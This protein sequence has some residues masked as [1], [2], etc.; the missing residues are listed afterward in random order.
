MVEDSVDLSFVKDLQKFV[1]L[2]ADMR[3]GHYRPEGV[4]VVKRIFVT[5]V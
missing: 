5:P 3:W 2:A 1:S 4:D